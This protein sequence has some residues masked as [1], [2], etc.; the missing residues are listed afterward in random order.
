L[1]CCFLNL[2]FR[3]KEFLCKGKCGAEC[4]LNKTGCLS[5]E[6]RNVN[7]CRCCNSCGDGK[8]NFGETCRTCPIDCDTITCQNTI[9]ITLDKNVYEPRD[10]VI[11]TVKVYDKNNNLMPFI[12]FFTDIYLDGFY[13]VILHLGPRPLGFLICIRI[14]EQ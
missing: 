4:N 6:G 13:T 3:M 10:Q 12:E 14:M 5:D 11:I 8:I 1:L 7:D 2:Q 9:N